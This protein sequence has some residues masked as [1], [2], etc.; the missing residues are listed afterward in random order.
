M[1][2]VIE[3]QI[4]TPSTDLSKLEKQIQEEI[5]NW[6]RHVRMKM[7]SYDERKL[8]D[9]FIRSLRIIAKVVEE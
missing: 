1:K 8:I 4:D 9:E 2:P 5:E 6:E 7:T 3:F